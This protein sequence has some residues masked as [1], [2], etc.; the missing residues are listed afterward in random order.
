[1]RS[2]SGW[3]ARHVRCIVCGASCVRTAR[4]PNHER[5]GGADARIEHAAMRIEPKMGCFATV[6]VLPCARH[7]GSK[8]RR[9]E[10][11]TTEGS[12][13]CAPLAVGDR[14]CSAH[15]TRP[16][17]GGAVRPERGC[18]VDAAAAGPQRHGD[19]QPA[20][21]AVGMGW[22]SGLGALRRVGGWGVGEPWCV[23]MVG[24]AGDA[25]RAGGA[26]DPI[27]SE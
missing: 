16:P 20:G 3:C 14:R 17:G 26:W 9:C 5:V 7:M 11:G 25:A 27:D 8:R 6:P 18:A 24:C 4:S 2:G 13:C 12:T 21:G 1:M 15:G 19:D 10:E 23:A 22:R